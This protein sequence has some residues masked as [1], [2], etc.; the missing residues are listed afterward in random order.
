MGAVASQE[1]PLRE[2]WPTLDR[3]RCGSGSGSKA[4][5]WLLAKCKDPS[6]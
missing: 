6:G 4:F 5:E 3:C 1:V 2:R